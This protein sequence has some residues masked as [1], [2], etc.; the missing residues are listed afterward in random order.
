MYES[1]DQFKPA[2]QHKGGE[3]I[4]IEGPVLVPVAPV[5]MHVIMHWHTSTV[6]CVCCYIHACVCACV[7][8]QFLSRTVAAVDIKRGDMGDYRGSSPQQT[9]E[10]DPA[11]CISF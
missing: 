3:V 6:D 7:C 5:I 1:Q 9:N 2:A 4:T 11:V 10:A 8:K